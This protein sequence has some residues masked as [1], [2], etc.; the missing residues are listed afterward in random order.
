MCLYCF[1][2]A[3]VKIEKGGSLKLSKNVVTR[4]QSEFDQDQEAS[5]Q[6]QSDPT[7]SARR[8]LKRRD[9]LISKFFSRKKSEKEI[10]TFSGQFPPPPAFSDPAP[11]PPAPQPPAA[12]PVK[13]GEGEHIYS[14]PR[15]TPPPRPLSART[16]LS[17]LHLLRSRENGKISNSSATLQPNLKTFLSK[18]S[19]SPPTNTERFTAENDSA[20]ALEKCHDRISSPSSPKSVTFFHESEPTSYSGGD[21]LRPERRAL[22]HRGRQARLRSPPSKRS[23]KYSSLSSASPSSSPTSGI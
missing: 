7:P 12:S 9:S 6:T 1:Q 2:E 17:Q 18:T 20:P 4:L 5:L 13:E 14:V 3:R 23:L 15:L 10:G 22:P 19:R 16:S 21:R 8:H 11:Q